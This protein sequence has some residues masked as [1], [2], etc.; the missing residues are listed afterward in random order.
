MEINKRSHLMRSN[1]LYTIYIE[2]NLVACARPLNFTLKEIY[3]PD[4]ILCCRPAASPKRKR[5]QFL[6]QQTAQQIRA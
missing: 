4:F 1:I 2:A 6:F 3:H 5:A